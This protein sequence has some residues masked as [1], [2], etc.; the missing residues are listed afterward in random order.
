MGG[1]PFVLLPDLLSGKFFFRGLL[2]RTHPGQP[3]CRRFFEA[4]ERNEGF[5]GTESSG[6]GDQ[7]TTR[8][9]THSVLAIRSHAHIDFS[10][11]SLVFSVAPIGAFTI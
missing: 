3:G 7:D 4:A 2:D 6:K 11:R 10:A 5:P 9:G 8:K 1:Y